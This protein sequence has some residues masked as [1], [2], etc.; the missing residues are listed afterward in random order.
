MEV[1]RTVGHVYLVGGHVVAELAVVD[2]VVGER[3]G[4]TPGVEVEG[5]RRGDFVF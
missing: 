4:A 3:R 5:A 1:R 2:D